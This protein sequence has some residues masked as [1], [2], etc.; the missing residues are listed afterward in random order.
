MPQMADKYTR[1]IVVLH[2]I[3]LSLNGG[4][5]TIWNVGVTFSKHAENKGR[6]L[7]IVKHCKKNEYIYGVLIS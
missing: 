4:L 6:R 2:K 7:R 3:I 1:L 5:K